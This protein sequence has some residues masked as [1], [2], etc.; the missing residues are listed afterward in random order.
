M[1][2]VPVTGGDERDLGNKKTPPRGRRG[3]YA[4]SK[5]AGRESVMDQSKTRATEWRPKMKRPGDTSAPG[6]WSGILMRR[7]TL[8]PF[9]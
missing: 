2:L 1:N 7:A 5:G 3:E 4:L 6:R 9:A 8:G